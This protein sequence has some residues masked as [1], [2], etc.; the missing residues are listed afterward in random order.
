MEF[1]L[2]PLLA[3]LPLF[4][5]KSSS[6]RYIALGAALLNLGLTFYRLSTFNADGSL[7][8]V[9]DVTWIEAAGIHFK[10]GMDGISM[11]LVLLTN[12]LI[13]VIIQASDRKSVV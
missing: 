6:A 3:A 10:V 1:L 4:F 12:L 2:I 5:I 8:F 13:P 7:N 9:T 11:L